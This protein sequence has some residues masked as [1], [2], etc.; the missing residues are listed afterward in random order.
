M[1]HLRVT[2]PASMLPPTLDEIPVFLMEARRTLHLSQEQLGQIMGLSKR[3]II[4]MEQGR[5]TPI[6]SQ[7]ERVARVLYPKDAALAGH[8]AAAAGTTLEAMG[9]VT[10][11]PAPDPAAS[12]PMADS[13]VCVAAEAMDASP[14]AVRPALVAAFERMRSL[15]IGVDAVLLGLGADNRQGARSA[16]KSD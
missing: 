6:P 4:R 15:G 16:K 11:A 3:T 14:R 9:L 7:Y 2:L 13:I 12:K 10:A 5:S 8:Y 1:W